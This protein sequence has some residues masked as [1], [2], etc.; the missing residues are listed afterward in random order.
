LAANFATFSSH[1]M[2]ERSSHAEEQWRDGHNR[3]K[4]MMDINDLQ[5]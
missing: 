5:N 3:D 2:N 1:A 4:N